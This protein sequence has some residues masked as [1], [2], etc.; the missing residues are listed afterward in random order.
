VAVSAEIEK[1][2]YLPKIPT[3]RKFLIEKTEENHHQHFVF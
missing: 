2:K 3:G 1:E